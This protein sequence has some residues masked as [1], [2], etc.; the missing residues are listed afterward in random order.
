MGMAAAS[1]QK[2]KSKSTRKSSLLPKGPR[3]D[4]E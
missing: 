1:G 2:D 4:L 3:E